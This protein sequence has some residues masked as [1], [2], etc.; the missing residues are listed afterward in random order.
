MAKSLSVPLKNVAKTIRNV[1]SKLA[2]RD[3]GNLRNVLRSYNTP[4][5]MTKIDKNG[6]AK[7]ILFFA[8]PGATYGKYWNKPY[9]RGTGTTATIRKRYPQHFDYADKA[10]KSPE[11]KAAIK[12]YTKALGK[13]IATDLREA[14]RKG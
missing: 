6:N 10:Y 2:P 8:P 7:I 5:R 3:T 13:S 1:A 4:E 14:V 12:E 9:G 11:V